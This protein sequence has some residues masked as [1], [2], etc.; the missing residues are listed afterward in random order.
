[1]VDMVRIGEMALMVGRDEEDLRMKDQG[2]IEN[3]G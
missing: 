2:K 3:R 1:M